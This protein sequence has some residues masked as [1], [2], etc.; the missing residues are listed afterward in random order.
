MHKKFL[1]ICQNIVFFERLIMKL[2]S[3][4]QTNE[5]TTKILKN[6]AILNLNSGNA[7]QFLQRK[8]VWLNFFVKSG[9]MWPNFEFC[10]NLQ[11]KLIFQRI[12]RGQKCHLEKR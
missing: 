1:K 5:N 8:G 12:W 6:N 11:S 3:N 10:V 4:I 2:L 9:V 7:F